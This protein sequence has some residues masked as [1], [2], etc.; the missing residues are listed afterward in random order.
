[1]PSGGRGMSVGWEGSLHIQKYVLDFIT[2][3]HSH[4]VVYRDY[5]ALPVKERILLSGLMY[6]PHFRLIM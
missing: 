4:R 5:L 2:T 1:M 3:A 6:F